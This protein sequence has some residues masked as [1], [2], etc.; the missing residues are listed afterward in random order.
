MTEAS[1]SVGL[2]LA[3]ALHLGL[4]IYLTRQ[5]MDHKALKSFI[6]VILFC[7]VQVSDSQGQEVPSQVNVWWDHRD[8]ISTAKYEVRNQI[9]K[10]G[11][12]Q[13]SSVVKLS[14]HMTGDLWG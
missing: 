9:N 3:T 11:C 1:A 6:I 7:P 5:S 14:L 10:P 8:R 2:L 12:L 13:W 4:S